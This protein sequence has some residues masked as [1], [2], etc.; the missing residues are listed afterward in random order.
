MQAMV[1]T[2]VMIN[3]MIKSCVRRHQISTELKKIT[4]LIILANETTVKEVITQTVILKVE[5][6]R[7]SH[8][9]SLNIMLLLKHDLIL[10][11]SWLKKQKLKIDFEQ[12]TVEERKYVKKI[13]LAYAEEVT[14]ELRKFMILNLS[15]ILKKYHDFAD[16]FQKAAADQLSE[17]RS[18][19]HE[20][21]LIKEKKST[22]RSLYSLSE[23][24][25]AACRAWIKENKKKEFI[26]KLQSLA[27][28][29]ILFIKK[30]NDTLRL[31]VDYR[32]LNIITKKNWMTSSLINELLERL[33]K[34]VIFIKLDLRGVYNLL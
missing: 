28:A 21:P 20:I 9:L 25:A 13:V 23:V 27:E 17:H 18:Y 10:E 3:F 22:F 7:L 11:M 31:C 1:D 24:E 15:R 34:T 14:V 5:H 2:G 19:D 32:K 33:W 26:H 30:K 16:L 12:D 6:S 8:I 29:L 4:E